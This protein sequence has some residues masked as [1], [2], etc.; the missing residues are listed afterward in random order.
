MAFETDPRRAS[1]PQTF[2]P[3]RNWKLFFFF[4]FF[5]AELVMEAGDTEV[6]AGI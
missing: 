5:S 6:H 1:E 3:P 2:Y 4:P